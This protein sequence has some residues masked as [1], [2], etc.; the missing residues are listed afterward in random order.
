MAL[1]SR[2]VRCFLVLAEEL[3]FGRAAARLGIV[4]SALS[5]QIAR[6]EDILG[7]KLLSRGRRAAVRLTPLGE[8]FLAEAREAVARLD[9]A[10][11]VGRRAAE[12]RAGRAALGYVFSAALGGVLTRVLRAIRQDLPLID[13]SIYPLD[14]PEQIK[15]IAEARLDAGLLRPQAHYPKGICA[16]IVHRDPVQ[17]VLAGTHKLAIS[18]AIEP[19]ALAGET[20]LV[21]QAGRSMGLAGVLDDLAEVGNFAAPTVS[22]A[23]DFISATSLA[24]AGYGVVLAPQSLCHLSIEGIVFRPIANFEGVF[25]LALAWHG[26]AS[27]IVR[28]ILAKLAV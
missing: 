9:R 10:E 27:S 18:A 13:L 5:T 7:G 1:D 2:H 19:A 8:T 21:P 3:H 4:Q 26:D 24:A 28:T 11:R 15:A 20:F 25:D 6:L 14:S 12:G 17:L 16:Q 23:H 22:D